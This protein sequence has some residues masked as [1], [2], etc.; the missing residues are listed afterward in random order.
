M[1]I[2]VS[3]HVSPAAAGFG[4]VGLQRKKKGDADFHSNSTCNVISGLKNWGILGL[5]LANAD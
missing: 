4:R 3:A 2:P 1:L 5:Y